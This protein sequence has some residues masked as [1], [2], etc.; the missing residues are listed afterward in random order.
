[1]EQTNVRLETPTAKPPKR[2]LN[3]KEVAAYLG[4]SRYTIFRLIR[5]REIPFIPFGRARRF[6]VQAIDQWLLKRTIAPRHL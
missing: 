1:M 2:F 5:L 6:D 4:V 3:V